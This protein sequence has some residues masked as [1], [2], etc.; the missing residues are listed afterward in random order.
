LKAAQKSGPSKAE[1]LYLQGRAH[2]KA[3]DLAMAEVAYKEVLRLIPT[4]PDAL[5]MLGVAAFQQDRFEE[6]ERLLATAIRRIPKPALAYYNYGN[7]LRKLGRFEEAINAFIRSFELDPSNITCL[8][9]LGNIHKELNQFG[10]A[11]EYYD[12]LLEL[13]PTNAIGRSNKAIALLT[14]GR[15]AEGWEL[16]ESRLDQ[17]LGNSL[18]M[19]ENLPRLAP[20]W[21]GCIP[22]KPLL[23]LP[24]QGLGD[25]IFY[26]GMLADLESAGVDCLVCVEDRLIALFRRSFPKLMFAIPTQLTGLYERE[27]QFGAQ[28]TMASL[29]RWLRTSEQDFKKISSPFL[30]CDKSRATALRRQLKKP[31]RL[32]VGL[33]WQSLRTEHGAS[34]SCSLSQLLPALKSENV[35]FIDLQYGDTGEERALLKASEGVEI[36]RLDAIDNKLDVDGLAAL[37]D[38]CDIVL[39]ISNTTAHL[40]A[41]LGKPT[42]VLLP[43]HTPLWYWHLNSMDSRWYPSAVLLRQGTSGDWSEPVTQAAKI[44]KELAH[45]CGER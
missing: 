9:Q 28:I 20:E 35:D 21:D 43:W 27:N 22:P 4:Q 3:G 34:K 8:E 13:D 6:A 12:Q 23:V 36:R 15:L 18:P 14:E 7:A 31:N 40:S 33:S 37:I 1:R 5:H 11:H 16:Y 19:L 29:G 10:K 38:A 24:E 26:G 32:L 2:H 42:L 41:A 39:T 25:Q 30:H 44:I 45:E 17:Q